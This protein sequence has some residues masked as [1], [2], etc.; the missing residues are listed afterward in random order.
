M[1]NYR[2]NITKN[3]IA[4]NNTIRQLLTEMDNLNSLPRVSNVANSAFEP[5]QQDTPPP[6]GW[7]KEYVNGPP[8]SEITREDGTI[9]IWTGK[10][11]V[12]KSDWD[13]RIHD[14]KDWID[15]KKWLENPVTYDV[16]G[17]IKKW[18]RGKSK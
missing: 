11:W 6:E 9:M 1:N 3:N 13:G 18:G 7:G 8:G 4:L 2:N 17:H 15:Y 14:G 16:N 5:P 10:S 12:K